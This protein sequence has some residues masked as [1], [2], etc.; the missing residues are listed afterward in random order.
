MARDRRKRQRPHK[1]LRPP[2]HH[3]MRIKPGI[4]Q[5]P[6]QLHG[7]IGSN[8]PADTNRYLHST[9]THTR[10]LRPTTYEQMVSHP[11]MPSHLAFRS[12]IEGRCAGDTL[13]RV[14]RFEPSYPV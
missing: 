11:T 8:S 6:Y 4:L 1:L 7:L 3:H 13:A 14:P 10:I 9:I 2:R 12:L 5:Q